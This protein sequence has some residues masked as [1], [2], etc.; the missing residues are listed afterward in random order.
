MRCL[1]LTLLVALSTATS[2]TPALAAQFQDGAYK[3]KTVGGKSVQFTVASGKITAV[4]LTFKVVCQSDK[5]KESGEA[6]LAGPITVKQNGSFLA[7]FK[8]A[9]QLVVKS[10]TKD[11]MPSDGVPP[12]AD[13]F[14]KGTL[15]GSKAKG[16]A[17]VSYSY[18]E[19][20]DDP[21][22]YLYNCGGNDG[23]TL[24][25]KFTARKR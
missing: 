2:V 14:I 3:G 11:G 20:P 1:I 18:G 7:Y 12:S 5:H 15:S 4:K 21:S 25:V 8:Q 19:E 24:P 6:T 17:A 16:T 10:G 9:T 22:A 13:I 23:G